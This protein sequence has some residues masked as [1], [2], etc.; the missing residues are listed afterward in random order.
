MSFCMPQV[1]SFSNTAWQRAFLSLNHNRLEI[2]FLKFV[3][4]IW[5]FWN[6]YHSKCK[7]RAAENFLYL[8]FTGPFIQV[9]M[10][11]S[12]VYLG[13]SLQSTVVGPRSSRWPGGPCTIFTG[14]TK[15][16]YKCRFL[17]LRRY[18]KVYWRWGETG[19]VRMRGW[20]H[21]PSIPILSAL[22]KYSVESVLSGSLML[23]S[24]LALRMRF[25]CPLTAPGRCGSFSHRAASRAASRC[26]DHAPPP[27]R[28]LCCTAWPTRSRLRLKLFLQ[29]KMA[30]LEGNLGEVNEHMETLEFKTN[31]AVLPKNLGCWSGWLRAQG[32]EQIIWVWLLVS[33]YSV[34]SLGVKSLCILAPISFQSRANHISCLIGGCEDSVMCGKYLETFKFKRKALSMMGTI[35]NH[36]RYPEDLKKKNPIDT[37]NPCFSQEWG[38]IKLYV[39]ELCKVVLIISG[40]N[41]HHSVIF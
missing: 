39:M 16:N 30:W 19:E 20:D 13:T 38:T 33:I 32:L 15:H 4:L 17:R 8:V 34:Y 3:F 12:Q 22:G 18:R 14:C 36:H 5:T 29:N 27:S 41:D 31:V 2:F 35:V 37:G 21:P 28:P 23:Q 7:L 40:E 1:K 24:S 10:P 26:R 9:K 11:H 25:L 6:T